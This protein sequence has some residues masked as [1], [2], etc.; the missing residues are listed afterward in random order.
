MIAA[1]EFDAAQGG[2]TKMYQNTLRKLKDNKCYVDGTESYEGEKEEENGE[3]KT[4]STPKKRKGA[5]A[6]DGAKSPSP[7]KRASSKKNVMVKA[8]PEVAEGEG[9]GIKA[10]PSG[11]E[12]G[13]DERA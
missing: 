11:A 4:P 2:F 5:A 8:D 13:D 12:D 10:E 9:E 6:A 1:K 3:M 7:K